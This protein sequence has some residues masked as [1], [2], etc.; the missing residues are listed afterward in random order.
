M[1]IK[2]ACLAGLLA[3]LSG[4]A[5]A[6]PKLS[7]V[8]DLTSFRSTLED[9]DPNDGIV[10]SMTEVFQGRSVEACISRPIPATC[11]P[12]H[13]VG[14]QVQTLD[15][16][17]AIE[18][19]G[20]VP[21]L[22]AEARADATQLSGVAEGTRP[23]GDIG[24]RAAEAY[25]MT[26]SGAARYTA[27]VDYHLEGSGFDDT[28]PVGSAIAGM[29]LADEGSLWL[30]QLLVGSMFQTP[31]ASRHG[32]LRMTFDVADRQEFVRITYLFTQTYGPFGPVAPVPEP[33]TLAMGLTG[34]ALTALGIRRRRK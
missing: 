16:G 19:I 31:S 25:R 29:R 32:T 34:L 30:D 6:V 23:T 5:S 15:P 9:T 28:F 13:P 10:A 7:T 20:V 26:F 11:S 8:I 2:T 4:T 27:E 17:Q 22:R 1:L 12:F 18:T 14:P 3:A 24:A 33:G 21:E